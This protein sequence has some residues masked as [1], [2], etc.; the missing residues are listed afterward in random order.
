MASVDAD[1]LMWSELSSRG[2]DSVRDLTD[3]ESFDL[4]S[5]YAVWIPVTTY[6]KTPWLAP[7]AVRRSRNRVDHRAPGEKRDLWGFPDENGY[8][9]DDNSLIKQVHKGKTV[10]PSGQPYQSLSLSSGMVC[11]HVWAGTTQSPLLFSFVP[12]LVWLP[13]SLAPLSDNH[14]EGDAH[15]VHDYLKGVS[16]QRYAGCKVENGLARAV[17]SWALLDCEDVE[18]ITEPSIELSHPEKLVTLARDRVTRMTNFLEPLVEG[19]ERPKRFSRRYHAGVGTG[20]D[21]TCPSVDSIVPIESLRALLADMRS[22]QQ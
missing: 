17:S 9:T 19:G 21:H 18:S 16:L 4:V 3:E 11:C 1:V 20:I 7:Y 14:V 15:P 22:C 13:K 10:E 8:F 5:R 6:V 2:I 12:N